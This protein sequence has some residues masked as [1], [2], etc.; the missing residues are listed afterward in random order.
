[1]NAN[2]KNKILNLK[3]EISILVFIRVY[4]RNSRLML[5][6]FNFGNYKFWQLWQSLFS[7]LSS[8]PWSFPHLPPQPLIPPERLARFVTPSLSPDRQ[9]ASCSILPA[10]SPL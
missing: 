6:I 4:S 2:L 10:S 9:P 8:E 1:M 3:F 7:V 5:L